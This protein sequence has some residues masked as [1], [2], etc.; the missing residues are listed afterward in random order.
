M[1]DAFLAGE[2]PRLALLRAQAQVCTV[3]ARR[4]S[5]VGCFTELDVPDTAS[6]V[7]P[8]AMTFG[9]VDVRVQGLPPG[10][11]SMVFVR[12]GALALLEFVASAGDWP[13]DPVATG[14]SYIRYQPKPAGG[15]TFI[16][17]PVRDHDTLLLQLAGHKSSTVKAHT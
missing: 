16:P 3:A 12:R 5:G 6:R 1:L 7:A 11:S 8:P 2:D 17:T 13:T 9:D 15:Y 14:I 4:H 10:V